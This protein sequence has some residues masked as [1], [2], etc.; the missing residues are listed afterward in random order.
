MDHGLLPY[1]YSAV[2]RSI[3]P[4][5]H[6][7]KQGIMPG[8][9]YGV[10]AGYNDCWWSIEDKNA[11]PSHVHSHIH[12]CASPAATSFITAEVQLSTFLWNKLLLHLLPPIET[13][14]TDS[15]V[16]KSQNLLAGT[17]GLSWGHHLL[18]KNR[19]CK[20]SV[21]SMSEIHMSKLQIY[22][23]KIYFSHCLILLKLSYLCLFKFTV[24]VIFD[25][26]KILG[27]S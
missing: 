2:S 10:S 20:T 16:E 11:P 22:K 7:L 4:S 3:F 24:V 25:F 18:R 15:D 5:P 8:K 26:I 27:L 14:N 9:D 21:P 23:T 19:C 6:C 1:R 17:S 12:P 13:K